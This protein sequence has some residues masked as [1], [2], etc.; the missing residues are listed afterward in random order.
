[1]DVSKDN[2][3]GIGISNVKRRLAILHPGKHNLDI[4]NE[5]EMF[6]ID[7]SIYLSN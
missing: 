4:V 5:G 2:N 6:T 7:L 3:S 1:M